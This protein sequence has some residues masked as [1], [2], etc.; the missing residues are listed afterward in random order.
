MLSILFIFLSY[1]FLTQAAI[2]SC[3]FESPCN[4]FLTAYNW[5]KTDG[6]NPQG[7]DYDHTL[8]TSAGH[9]LYYDPNLSWQ[10]PIAEISTQNW[11]EP[12]TNGTLC[13]QMWYYTPRINFPFSIQLV[14]GDD[15]KLIRIVA[16]IPGRNFSFT[17]WTP[18]KVELPNEKFKIYIRTNVTIKGLA[19]DDLSVDYC[20]SSKPFPPKTLYS[21][22][23]ESSCSENFVTLP[24]YPYQWAILNATDAKKIEKNA[25]LADYTVG[26]GSGH[27]A[28][29]LDSQSTKVG[30]VGYL[31]LQKEFQITSE[32]TY[33]LNFQYYGFGYSYKSYLTISSW[34]T[35]SSKTV[36]VLWPGMSAMGYS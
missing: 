16:S 13:F 35:D 28:L 15:E 26:N 4:D 10:Y 24:A 34:T 6:Q 18:I 23:F 17:D 22:D 27:Y 31:H 14:Q 12:S 8:N 5:G 32:Q 7:I 20:E 33:C 11:L 29:V 36:E 21:C 9:Y 3:D 19:F 1:G 2:L 30:N 25:P